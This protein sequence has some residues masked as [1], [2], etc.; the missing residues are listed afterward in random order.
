[1][2]RFITRYR[3]NQ[4]LAVKFSF[5]QL[6]LHLPY[7]GMSFGFPETPTPLQRGRSWACLLDGAAAAALDLPWPLPTSHNS[8]P[9]GFPLPVLQ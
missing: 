6:S 5:L 4:V 9:A 2:A 7:M 1:M 3:Q 8:M